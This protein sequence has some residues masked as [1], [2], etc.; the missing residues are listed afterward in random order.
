MVAKISNKNLINKLSSF[1]Q[2]K[3]KKSKNQYSC[4]SVIYG[5]V[6]ETESNTNI[7]TSICFASIHAKLE[8]FNKN[9]NFYY[10]I[11]HV[12]ELF[13]MSSLIKELNTLFEYY[14]EIRKI[15][16]GQP[17]SLI[18]EVC[19]IKGFE[20]NV[21]KHCTLILL[22]VIIRAM[23][24]E[25]A[26]MILSNRKGKKTP[27][28][29]NITEL[30]KEFIPASNMGHNVNDAISYIYR[31]RNKSL[32]NSAIKRYLMTISAICGVERNNKLKIKEPIKEFMKGYRAR[33]T[34]IRQTTSYK[35]LEHI[36]NTSQKEKA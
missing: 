11:T 33:F 25:G 1:I 32:F 23:D 13:N 14:I 36:Y 20:N 29:K 22:S 16:S 17:N 18:L 12:P 10:V 8:K 5:T 9:T 28:I 30:L 34:F 15:N 2:Y 4:Q 35:I 21:I 7:S 6:S 26:R 27:K 31:T 3:N 19:N 24:E